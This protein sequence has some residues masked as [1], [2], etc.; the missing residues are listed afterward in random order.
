MSVEIAVAL[1]VMLVLAVHEG[2]GISLRDR[3]QCGILLHESGGGLHDSGTAAGFCCAKLV[4]VGHSVFRLLR[5]VHEL[6][7]CNPPDYG[8]LR[9]PHRTAVGRLGAGKRAAVDPDGRSVGLQPGGCSHGSADAGA[10]DGEKGHEQGILL[11]GYRR[12]GYDYPPDS[13]GNR[14]DPV[15]LPGQRLQSGKLFSFQASVW[16]FCCAWAKWS[17][18]R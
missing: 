3:G 6:F 11:G 7:R 12:F 18:C 17:R 2:A 8:P 4:P 9:Y 13:P 5:R 10:R 14:H 15:R 16:A 1:I